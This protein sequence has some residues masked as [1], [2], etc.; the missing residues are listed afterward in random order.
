MCVCAMCVCASVPVLLCIRVCIALAY[1][2][3]LKG[4]SVHISIKFLAVCHKKF[5]KKEKKQHRKLHKK[6]SQTSQLF[7]HTVI[8]STSQCQI[9]WQEMNVINAASNDA[10]Y[11]IWMWVWV[12]ANTS[13]CFL[14]HIS[15][16]EFKFSWQSFQFGIEASFDIVMFW[17]FFTIYLLFSYI[18]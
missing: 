13:E 2:L 9:L 3:Q 14:C 1:V 11:S 15:L 12:H 18:F 8:S 10:N 6:T 17:F 16:A 7:L 4:T 5:E